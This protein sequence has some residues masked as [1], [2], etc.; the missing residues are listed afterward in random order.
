MGE[1]QN[2]PAGDPELDDLSRRSARLVRQSRELA[3]EV[4]R[5]TAEVMEMQNQPVEG[6]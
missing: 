2:V 4:E 5:V 1:E 6:T 3:D